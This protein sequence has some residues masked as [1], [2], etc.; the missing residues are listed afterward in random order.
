VS[1]K[2]VMG[3]TSAKRRRNRAWPEALKR[4]IVGASLV[5]G[6]SVSV[7]ARSYDVNANQVFSW[8]KRYR[9]A[10]PAAAIAAAPRL[11]PVMVTPDR[12]TAAEQAPQAAEMIEIGFGDYRVRVGSAVDAQALRRVIDVLER[13]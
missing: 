13:R 8:R 1:T 5:P 4:E 12:N 9:D 7:V 3:T 10:G 11:I 2:S 6:A